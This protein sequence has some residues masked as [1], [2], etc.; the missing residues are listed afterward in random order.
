VLWIVDLVH[1][2]L[3]QS[4]ILR[5]RAHGR[6]L[7]VRLTRSQFYLQQHR[8]F[9]HK[10]LLV[11]STCLD[12][13]LVPLRDSVPAHVITPLTEQSIFCASFHC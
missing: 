2:S 9:P 4:R 6:R 8:A 5:A 13:R 1:Q 10:P 11:S 3:C 12:C 7:S